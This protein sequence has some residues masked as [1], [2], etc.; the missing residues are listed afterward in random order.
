MVTKKIDLEG[1]FGLLFVLE[2]IAGWERQR[3]I[4][5]STGEME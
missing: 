3:A 1:E 2:K 4:L 5:R